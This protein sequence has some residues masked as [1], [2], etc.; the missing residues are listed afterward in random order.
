MRIRIRAAR[1]DEAEQL[2]E[3]ARR[4]KAHWGYPAAQIERWR[5]TFLSVTADYI[6]AHAVWSAVD[7]ADCPLAFAAL[8]RA[9]GCD[10]LEHLW[11]LPEFIGMGIGRRL[12][13]QVA[14]ES[15]SF[16]FTSD[17]HADAFYKRMG[18]RVIGQVASDS[19]GRWLTKFRY[20]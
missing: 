17:P 3:I 20:P 18:A 7:Q 13:Q 8:E 2:S 19:Q 16:T 11:V 4:S 5:G 6:A 14:S 1:P 15:P 12:F 9:S 10:V